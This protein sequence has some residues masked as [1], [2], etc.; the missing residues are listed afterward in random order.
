MANA[1]WLTIGSNIHKG[2]IAGLVGSEL[3][4]KTP[5]GQISLTIA[6]QC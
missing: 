4:R 6:S 5:I 1:F 3:D 2:S